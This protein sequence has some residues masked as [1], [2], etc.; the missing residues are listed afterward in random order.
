MPL[1]RMR[2]IS[3]LTASVPAT[4]RRWSESTT[5]GVNAGSATAMPGAS[6]NSRAAKNEGAR[7][8]RWGIDRFSAAGQRNT[9]GFGDT[10]A[11]PERNVDMSE[12]TDLAA[13]ELG[14]AIAADDASC[15][16]VMQ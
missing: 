15:R 5:L 12:L 13:H 3:A 10:T 14:A 8:T 2:R 6:A 9:I 11:F 16:D 7:E 1:A 4:S